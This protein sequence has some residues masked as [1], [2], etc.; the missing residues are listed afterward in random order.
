MST[1]EENTILHVQVRVRARTQ[2]QGA[3]ESRQRAERSRHALRGRYFL[4]IDHPN[5]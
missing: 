5:V 4:Q 1:V 3:S 2:G